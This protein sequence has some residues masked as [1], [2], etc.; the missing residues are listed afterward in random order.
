MLLNKSI[1]NNQKFIKKLF[2]FLILKNIDSSVQLNFF[3]FN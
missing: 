3:D 2:V 1:Y